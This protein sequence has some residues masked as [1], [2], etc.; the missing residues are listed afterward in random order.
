VIIR[1]VIR[2]GAVCLA[3]L[4]LASWLVYSP[5]MAWSVVAGGVL[6]LVSFAFS[7][8]NVRK[9]TGGVLA[10]DDFDRQIARGKQETWSCILGFFLRLLMM[11]LVL[12]PLIKHKWVEI[13]GL[14]IGL[15]VV[16]LAISVVGVVMAGRL[17]LHGR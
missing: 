16:P 4:A 9:L 3:L 14:V 10:D 11:A 6:T 17:F 12:F 7:V 8:R 2:T 13:F 15:S 1:D 5:K